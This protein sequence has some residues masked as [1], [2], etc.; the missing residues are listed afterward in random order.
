MSELVNRLTSQTDLSCDL[1]H[2]GL[3]AL[4]NF[5]KKELGEETFDKLK[6]SVPDA[7]PITDRYE[8][9]PPPSATQGSLLEMVAGLA[10]K[11]LGGKAGEGANLV[12]TLSRLGFK[13]E[14]IE[15]FLPK[16]LE[17]IK[18]YL[19]PELIQRVLASLPALAKILAPEGK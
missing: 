10:S 6:E 15:S 9:S 5:L 4:F 3:G 2:Q 16:A 1:V 19:S 8:E 18:S 7:G 13:P 12:A 14:Q 17:L 11:V